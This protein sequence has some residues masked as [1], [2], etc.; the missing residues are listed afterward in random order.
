MGSVT[1]VFAI[2]AF[3]FALDATNKYNKLEKRVKELE[4]NKS[5]E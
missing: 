2:I 5:S 3:V 1:F 4:N